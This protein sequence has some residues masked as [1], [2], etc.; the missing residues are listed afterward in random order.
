MDSPRIEYVNYRSPNGHRA[1]V[2]TLTLHDLSLRATTEY[3]A[4]IQR[5]DFL[6]F[7]LYTAGSGRHQVDFI[8]HE[9]RP[10]TL[11]IL[12]PG[13]T[14]RFFFNDSMH[15]RLLVVDRA[16]LLPDSPGATPLAQAETQ[17]PP[18]MV[19]P[20]DGVAEFLDTCAAIEADTRRHRDGRLFPQL[21]RQ[22]LHTW[23]M[24]L[25][26]HLE[27]AAAAPLL[28]RPQREQL[29][30]DFCA[31]LE[32]H[33][34]E[35]WSVADYA[36]KLR[37]SERTLSRLC[38][39]ACGE[40]AKATIDRRVLLEAKRW[41]GH[42]SDSVEVISLRLGFTDISNFLKFFK[43]LAGTTAGEFRRTIRG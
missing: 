31:L 14:H 19:L 33:H 8:D 3:L 18:C 39:A 27:D 17:W 5:V 15:G 7:I 35:R 2:E 32:Q 43:R 1:G 6:N 12:K 21:L 11:V 30:V 13:Q 26:I 23:A 34:G 29:F 40:S 4:S 16:F 20:D 9:V 42:S 37:C 28:A 25:Q 41:L 22:R 38:Q 24:L 10:G 36:Q